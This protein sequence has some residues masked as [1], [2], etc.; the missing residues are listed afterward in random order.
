M[1]FGE[2]LIA[3]RK[4]R[5]M[6][7]KELADRLDIPYTT[8]RNYETDQREPGHKTL[9]DLA[10]LFSVSVDELIGLKTVPQ[11]QKDAA[12]RIDTANGI[13]NRYKQLDNHGK[14][15]VCAVMVEEERRMNVDTARI[16]ELFPMRHYIQS[17]SAGLGDFADDDSFEIIDLVKRPP[18]G[19]SFLVTV[20]GDSMEPTYHNGQWVFIRVQETLQYG[21]IGLFA[22]GADLFIK[23]YGVNGLISHNPAYAVLQP[24]VDA[25]ARIYGK[26][27]GVCSSDYFR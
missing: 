2:N 20:N 16:I 24:P 1:S 14:L 6:T 3:I 25:P 8:L 19:A 11:K 9:I 4:S 27:L 17:A 23:E 13:A 5:G 10:K 18:A 7:R 21:E 22:I 12:P 15:V 26:V